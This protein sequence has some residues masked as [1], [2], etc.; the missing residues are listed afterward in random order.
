MASSVNLTRHEPR[1]R[2][3]SELSCMRLNMRAQRADLATP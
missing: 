1:A 2:C 3:A